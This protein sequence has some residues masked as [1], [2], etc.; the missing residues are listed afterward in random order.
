MKKIV[1]LLMGLVLTFLSFS[2]TNV[3]VGAGASF[4]YP[5]YSKWAYEYQKIKGVK[6]N[7]QSIGSGGGIQQ[8]S[9]KTVDFG[10][11]D[12]P[13]KSEELNTKGMIQFPMIIGGVVVIFNLDEIA[14]MTLKLDGETL[15]SIFLGEIKKWNDSR[16]AKL[17]PEIRLPDKDIT[18]VHR[19]DGSGT[20]FLFTHYLS[21]VSTRWKNLVGYGTAVEWPV[22][23][24]GKGNEGVASFVKQTSGSIGYVEYAYAKQN[25][26]KVTL[27]KNRDGNF[28]K[29]SLETF[30]EAAKSA[31]W[32]KA[33]NF[34]L[35]LTNQ[36]GQDAWPIVGASFIIIYK[37]QENYEK[38]RVMLQFF[39]WC[40]KN[41][42]DYAIGLHYVPIPEKVYNLIE[43]M[44]SEKVT[45]NGKKV[46]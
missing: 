46:F 15:A 1:I 5:I 18:V 13:L 19:A 24:G 33:D 25:K 20:S 9:N 39:E 28:V 17:N 8:I 10:A 45:A 3:L 11:S 37:N 6:L 38:A 29:P 21:Q 23:I 32:E 35:I 26:L 16:I 42:A 14:D 36:H 4:P 2:Q 27:L 40:F 41:G 34:N 43:K 30:S 31:E 12:A 7:Y 44:W 22:G